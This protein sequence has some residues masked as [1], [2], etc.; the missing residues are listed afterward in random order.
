MSAYRFKALRGNS[1]ELDK[2][3]LHGDAD[4]IIGL[5]PFHVQDV[6]IV[7]I[8][9]E[10]ILLAIP[11][12]ILE[13]YFPGHIEDVRQKLQD[14]SGLSLL[15]NCPFVMLRS[16][17]RVRTIANE[18]LTEAQVTPDIVL[19]AENIET[20]VAL[21]EKGMGITF[22]PKMFAA[23]PSGEPH[24]AH[25]F[26]SLTLCPLKHPMAHSTLA[27]GYHKSHYM[28]QATKEFIKMTQELFANKK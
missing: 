2:L 3:L 15:N 25:P 20:V 17:N 23:G 27:I 19:E 11:D 21:A 14:N 26:Q 7:P 9:R 22:Y 10:E 1:H 8:C 4:L 18:V 12:T 5:P 24:S 13:N 16:G 28:S 6:E